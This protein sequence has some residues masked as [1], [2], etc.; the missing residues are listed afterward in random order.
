ME[1]YGPLVVNWCRRW[2]AQEAD[3]LDVTQVVLAKLAVQMRRFAYDSSRS[4]R[5]WL[6][7]VALNAWRDSRDARRPDA[8]SGHS[9]TLDFLHNLE[10]RDD[11]VRR[12]EQQYDLELLDE[13][14]RRVRGRVQPRTWD[15]YELTAVQGVSGPR[16]RRGWASASARSSWPRRTCCGCSAKRSRPWTTNRSRRGRPRAERAAHAPAD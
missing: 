12:L 15:A 16:P 4:F 2:G 1:R 14:G 6:H 5:T 9:E 7:T 13:A 10:A 8:G 3:A 11:L